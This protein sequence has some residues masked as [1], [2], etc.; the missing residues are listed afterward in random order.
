MPGCELEVGFAAI[1]TNKFPAAAALRP[2]WSC[3]VLLSA[4]TETHMLRNDVDGEPNVEQRGLIACGS[5]RLS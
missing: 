4:R 2:A 3:S 1:S 5:I